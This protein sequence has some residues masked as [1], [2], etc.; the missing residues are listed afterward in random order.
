MAQETILKTKLREKRIS[1]RRAAPVLGVS[2][3]Y[4]SDVCN[5][6]HKSIRLS[7]K[8]FA[9]CN[10]EIPLPPRKQKRKK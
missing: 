5:G 9:L 3:Q 6:V 10:G 7:N 4:L 1:Y 2:Y 8:I